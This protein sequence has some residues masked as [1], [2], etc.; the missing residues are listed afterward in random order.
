ML[1]VRVSAVG[2]E[3][4]LLCFDDKMAFKR[5]RNVLVRWKSRVMKVKVSSFNSVSSLNVWSNN[6]TQTC[7]N[8]LMG[9]Q[10]KQ[11]VGLTSSKPSQF[12]SLPSF[13][14]LIKSLC[15][16]SAKI[17]T[18]KLL[19]KTQTLNSCAGKRKGVQP[20]HSTCKRVSSSLSL[21][22]EMHRRKNL[23]SNFLSKVTKLSK[24][25]GTFACKI[26][27]LSE[28]TLRWVFIGSTGVP[29]GVCCP[30]IEDIDERKPFGSFPPWMSGNNFGLE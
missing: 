26:G 10:L 9:I 12:L 27:K 24:P 5:S 18:Y 4:S 17:Y 6:P 14:L 30:F 20:V 23:S 29:A 16:F 19:N 11:I 13:F 22:C 2:G 15:F 21:F 28:P 8:L 25:F 7:L 1:V 3:G